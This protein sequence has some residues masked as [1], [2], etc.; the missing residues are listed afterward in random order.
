MPRPLAL[1]IEDDPQL[2]QI[3]SLTM[4]DDFEEETIIHGDAALSRLTA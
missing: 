1:I 2:S 4:P 3:F